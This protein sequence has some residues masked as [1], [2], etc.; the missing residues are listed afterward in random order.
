MWK[1]ICI[2]LLIFIFFFNVKVISQ[3]EKRVYV[4]CYHT[5]INGRVSFIDFSINELREQLLFLKSSGFSFITLD[6]FINGDIKKE[7][8]ILITIDD[9]NRSTYRAYK[10]VFKPMGIKPVLA[11]F[12]GVIQNRSWALTWDQLKELQKDG[13]SIVVHGYF[14][15]KLTNHFCNT[16]IRALERELI[17]SRQVLKN[18]LGKV[19]NIYVYPYGTHSKRVYFHLKNLGYDYAFTIDNGSIFFPLDNNIN[20]YALPRYML[21]RSNV[22]KILKKIVVE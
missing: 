22:D 18:I 8:N 1:K 9:G 11:I 4:L 2:S 21:T 14:H 5:F 12:V 7:K 16:R 20:C 10:E 15:S 3:S 13:C 19:H 17:T 6:D